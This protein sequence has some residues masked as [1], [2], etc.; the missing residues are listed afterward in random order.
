MIT[1]KQRAI[2][3]CYMSAL[4]KNVLFKICCQKCSSGMFFQFDIY[5]KLKKGS[6]KYHLTRAW[7]IKHIKW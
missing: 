4:Q 3:L 2:Q 7:H 6:D 5:A 1:A